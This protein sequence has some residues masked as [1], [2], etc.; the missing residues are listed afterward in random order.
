MQGRETDVA[1]GGDSILAF[2][3]FLK[4]GD[5]AQPEAIER[6]NEDHCRSTCSCATGCS[7]ASAMN[8]RTFALCEG[9]HNANE[10]LARIPV[11]RLSLEA[12]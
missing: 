5:R 4:T 1:E 11:G 10:R 7:S 9:S 2:E 12:L 6:Y 3:Q 8:E